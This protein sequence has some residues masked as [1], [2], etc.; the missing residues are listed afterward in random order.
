MLTTSTFA[1]G[2]KPCV[3]WTMPSP[4][5]HRF[6]WVIMASTPYRVS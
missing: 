1:A 6:R 4:C 3:V 5:R 2:C